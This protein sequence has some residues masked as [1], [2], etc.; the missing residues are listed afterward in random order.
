MSSPGKALA[1]WGNS[2]IQVRG[3]RIYPKLTIEEWG[4]FPFRED[5]L[6]TINTPRAGPPPALG[7]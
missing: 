4:N 1:R 2:L 5:H 7:S 3:A 6:P